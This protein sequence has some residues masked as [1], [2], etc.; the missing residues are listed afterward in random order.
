MGISNSINYLRLIMLIKNIDTA[1]FEISGS[2]IVFLCHILDTQI[3]L[4]A[5]C[6]NGHNYSFKLNMKEVNKYLPVSFFPRMCLNA[7]QITYPRCGR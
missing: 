6:K 5:L 1:Y 7:N 4:C 3:Y 2:K